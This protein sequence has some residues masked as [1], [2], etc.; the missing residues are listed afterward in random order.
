M[1][2]DRMMKK[3]SGVNDRDI[4]KKAYQ[5]KSIIDEDVSFC[6]NSLTVLN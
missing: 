4:L 3:L 5:S 1:G 6:K 2:I